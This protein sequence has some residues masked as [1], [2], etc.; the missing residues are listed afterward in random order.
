L[1][2][3]VFLFFPIASP[4]HVPQTAR[5]YRVGETLAKIIKDAGYPNELGFDQ[6]LYPN[7]VDIRKLLMFLMEQMPQQEVTELLNESFVCV[8]CLFVC[9]VGDMH[10]CIIID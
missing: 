10:A 4:C 9:F 2:F 8:C 5:G 6:F 7:E 1:L 3:P